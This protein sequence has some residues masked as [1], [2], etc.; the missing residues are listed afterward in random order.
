MNLHRTIK[1]ILSIL[2]LWIVLHIIYSTVDGLSDSGKSAD[3]AVILGSKVNEDGSLSLRLLQRLR[4]GLQLYQS[5]RVKSL[6]VSG[7]LGKEG[8]YEGDKMKAYLLKSGVPSERIF[9]DNKGDNTIATVENTL[10]LNDSLHYKSLLIVSQYF[11]ITRTKMLFKKRGFQNVYGVSPKYFE[12]RDIYSI[13]R[14]FAA[15]YAE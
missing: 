2:F 10:R 13:L 3:V 8:F 5:G 7:G 1:A 15:Y 9:V 6:I 14:E 4:C 11:H 12:L